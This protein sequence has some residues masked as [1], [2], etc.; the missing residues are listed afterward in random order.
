MK[1][2]GI[3]TS[4]LPLCFGSSEVDTVHFPSNRDIL[5]YILFLISTT[6][7]NKAAAFSDIAATIVT[8]EG[9]NRKDKIVK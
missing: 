3:I 7:W 6:G 2:A 5:A 4:Y 9:A 1:T 8:W